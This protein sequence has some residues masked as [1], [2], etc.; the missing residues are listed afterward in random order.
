MQAQSTVAW[1]K[2]A[3]AIVIAFGIIVTA[4]ASPSGAAIAGFLADVIFWPFDGAQAISAPEARLLSAISG[5]VMV[6]WGILL[7]LIASRL[8]PRDP[9]LAKTMILWSIGSWFVIDGAG[10]LMADAPLNVMFNIGFL[11]LFVVPLMR[12][13][14]AAPA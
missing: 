9:A 14:K 12:A 4:A 10:S 3:S 13:A 1:L 2:A 8:Y 11:L 7:W 5:G 6:G